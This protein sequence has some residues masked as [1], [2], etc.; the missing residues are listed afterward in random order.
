MRDFLPV[1]FVTC[2][3]G[4]MPHHWRSFVYHDHKMTGFGLKVEFTRVG[5]FLCAR[6]AQSWRI[7]GEMRQCTLSMR[8]RSMKVK[9]DE[10]A[11]RNEFGRDPDV[12]AC[13]PQGQAVVK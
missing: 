7:N 2:M 10:L 5:L 12:P 11:L 4:T 1:S 8:F 13:S 6:Q 3:S 9:A